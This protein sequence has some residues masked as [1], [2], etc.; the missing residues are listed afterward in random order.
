M[1]TDI[2][3][4]IVDG[5]GPAVTRS[6]TAL[7][8]ALWHWGRRGGGAQYTLEIARQLSTRDD[9]KLS[10]FL[11]AGVEDRPLYDELR[12]DTWYAATL[13]ST[14]PA[15]RVR[16]SD[17]LRLAVLTFNLPVLW[18]TFW[19]KLRSQDVVVCTMLHPLN[20]LVSW[21]IR[22]SGAKYVIVLHEPTSARVS[23]ASV[24]TAMTR[25]EARRAD[26]IVLL[27]DASV[28]D[29]R[30]H[31]PQNRALTTVL[32]MGSFRCSASRVRP[33]PSGRPVRL[34]F[35]GRIDEYKGIDLLIDAYKLLRQA[36]RAVTLAIFGAGDMRNQMEA[37][38]GVPDVEV[39]NRW[40]QH[41]ELASILDEHDVCIVPYRS[42]SQSGVVPMAQYAGLPVVATP[43]GGLVEQVAHGVT[44]LIV[45]EVSSQALASTIDSLLVPDLYESLSARAVE[46]ARVALDWA[47]IS[48]G[49][50]G[51]AAEVVRNGSHG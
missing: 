8:V 16:P 44:G 33:Y 22:L 18:M 50:L 41:T 35:F 9:V 36:G 25:M 7:R 17:Y 49:L 14:H 20:S 5:D 6:P 10:M 2:I 1:A 47:D 11:S 43:V 46:F 21:L 27:S 23:H 19:R 51:F 28:D 34:L 31:Y 15:T 32:P 3:R 26:G 40:I 38:E 39:Q 4:T 12:G 30:R 45:P 13:T 24:I 42:A 29:F 37:L 48:D